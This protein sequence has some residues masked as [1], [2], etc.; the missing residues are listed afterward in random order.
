[1]WNTNKQSK[2]KTQT[3]QKFRFTNPPFLSRS[4]SCRTLAARVSNSSCSRSRFRDNKAALDPATLPSTVWIPVSGRWKLATKSP[5]APK[6]L[7]FFWGGYP[8]RRNQLC[9]VFLPVNSTTHPISLSATMRLS[10][11]HVR[12]TVLQTTF[13]RLMAD[14][15]LVLYVGEAAITKRK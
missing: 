8:T 13:V 12:A 10:L 3:N 7:S 1:M 2:T 4:A 5:I 6:R 15:L 9:F 11:E 14:Y